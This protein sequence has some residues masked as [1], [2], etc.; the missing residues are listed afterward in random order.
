[1]TKITFKLLNENGC[2]MLIKLHSIKCIVTMHYIAMEID[3]I[4]QTNI[5]KILM[6]RLKTN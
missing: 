3:Y 4:L 2:H 5:R 1:M 6:Q